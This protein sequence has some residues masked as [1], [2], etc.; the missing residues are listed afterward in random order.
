MR[1]GLLVRTALVLLALGEGI[2]AAWAAAFPLSF[3]H[4]FPTPDRAWLTLFPP[5][6]E[7]MTR[8]F[9]MIA[10]PFVAVLLYAAA[11]PHRGLVRA[12]LLASLLFSV[13]HLLF[14]QNHLVSS[15]DIPVQVASQVVPI[16]VALVALALNERSTQRT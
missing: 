3:F 14:H 4:G 1:A 8:D 15:P 10:L 9:G 5:Y 7:H 11:I 2:P 12:V 13:P 6:N 16:A